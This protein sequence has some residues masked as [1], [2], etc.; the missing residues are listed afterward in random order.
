[1]SQTTIPL[2]ECPLCNHEPCRHSDCLCFDEDYLADLDDISTD[3]ELRR[4]IW[5]CYYHPSERAE[6]GLDDAKYQ[7]KLDR[8]QRITDKRKQIDAE[9]DTNRSRLF[10]SWGYT[11]PDISEAIDWTV[12]IE[13]VNKQCV[14][15]LRDGKKNREALTKEHSGMVRSNKAET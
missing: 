8:C 9:I 12:D 1:M 7:D 11:G 4:K 13:D 10:R 14:E 3:R 15:I 5:R 6:L 2:G